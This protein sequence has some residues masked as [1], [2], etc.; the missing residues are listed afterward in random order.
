MVWIFYLLNT[1]SIMPTKTKS[2]STPKKN[3]TAPKYDW[4][5]LKL[6]FFASDALSLEEWIR[7]ELGVP[8]KN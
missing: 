2:S 7:R 8:N 5:A 3:S 4:G 1:F 6:K